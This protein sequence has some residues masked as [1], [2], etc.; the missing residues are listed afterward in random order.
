[1]SASTAA[2]ILEVL[3]PG[4]RDTARRQLLL[5]QTAL[6]GIEFIEFEEIAGAP[7]RHVL[8]V[9][10]LIKIPPGAYGLLLDASPLHVHGGT[11]IVGVGVL[12]A[13]LSPTDPKVLDVDVDQQ[14][15][16]SPYLLTI[17]WTRD[18]Q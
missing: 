1:M 12:K 15:D 5:A 3:G 11:R 17:G 6:N 8:H 18:E 16:F 9:H 13:A 7:A 14:G 10:F 2:Q 4:C